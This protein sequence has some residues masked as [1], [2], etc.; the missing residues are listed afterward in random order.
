MMLA[1]AEEW[2]LYLEKEKKTLW[3][4]ALEREAESG[5]RDRDEIR[6]QMEQALAVM[7]R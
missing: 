2:I 6:A 5:K 3:Q 1:K 4:Y 7:E